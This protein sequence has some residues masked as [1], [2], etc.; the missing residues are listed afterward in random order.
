MLSFLRR[1]RWLV[2]GKD[3]RE[4]HVPLFSCEQFVLGWMPD[5][6]VVEEGGRMSSEHPLISIALCTFNGETYLP[7]QMES[8]LHQDWENLE[9]VAVDDGSTDGTREILSEFARRDARIRLYLNEQNLGF[10]S[11][12]QKAFALTKGDLVAPCDQDDWWHPTKLSR[13][14]AA[15]DGKDLAYCDSLLID[16]SGHSL[17]R[18]IS[19]ILEMYSGEDPA[20]FV[21]A[22]CISGHALLVKRSLLEEALPLPPGFFHD[23]WLA[24][25]ATARN[26]VVY[27]P[28]PLVHYRQHPTTQTHIGRKAD[29][30]ASRANRLEELIKIRKW[31]ECLASFP[32]KQQPYFQALLS[33][34]MKWEDSYACLKLA[35]LI[36]QR[37]ETLYYIDRHAAHQRLTR[38]MRNFVGL[39]TKKILNPHRYNGI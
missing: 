20:A 23:W 39:K 19:D 8:L 7:A 9:I 30:A 22:N 10:L 1:D 3:G 4:G 25:A 36:F 24:F 29:K 27:V 33:A 5:L 13:L 38:V 32:G 2:S 18:R 14:Q 17:N 12:F 21:F 37:K 34:R 26:G 11:N 15:I 28:E 35:R 6:H 16:E 31:M